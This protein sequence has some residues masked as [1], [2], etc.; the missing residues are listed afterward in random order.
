[1]WYSVIKIVHYILLFKGF[2]IWIM[3]INNCLSYGLTNE[4]CVHSFLWLKNEWIKANKRQQFWCPIESLNKSAT[5]ILNCSLFVVHIS[6]TFSTP[7]HQDF[8]SFVHIQFFMAFCFYIFMLVTCCNGW[9]AS[10]QTK[11]RRKEYNASGINLNRKQDSKV[12]KEIK[13]K[14]WNEKIFWIFFMLFV[15]SLYFNYNDILNPNRARK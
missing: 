5:A 7:H 8:R 6:V 12:T 2:F 11:M 4:K 9:I 14:V 13:I 10:K 1:M 3:I 15:F